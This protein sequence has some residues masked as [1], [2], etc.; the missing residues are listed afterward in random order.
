MLA[1]EAQEMTVERHAAMTRDAGVTTVPFG[2]KI[3]E[4]RM[5]KDAEELE[6]LAT[7][8]RLSSQALADV[9]PQIRPGLSERTLASLLDYRMTE[10]GADGVAFDT[11]VASGPN[12][13]I[14]HH[15]PTDRPLR[16]GDLVTMDF[17]ALYQGYHAD[18]TRTVAVGEPPAGS[19]TSTSSS[20]RR[21]GPG[22]RRSSP[23]PRPAPWT[24]PPAR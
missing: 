5:V 21:S 4:L 15:A 12:G 11:I 13:A 17:G 16:R 20:R 2:R 22:S 8:C 9:L 7:A 19:G 10:L 18:M 23:A 6:L 14:P 3:E 1:F 24:P